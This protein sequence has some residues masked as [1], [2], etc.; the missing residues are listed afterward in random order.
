MTITALKLFIWILIRCPD[1]V[2]ALFN[3]IATTPFSKAPW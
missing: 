3:L 1:H 2:I